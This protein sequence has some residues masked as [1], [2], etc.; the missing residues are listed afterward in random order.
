M[1]NHLYEHIGPILGTAAAVMAWRDGQKL[2]L[3]FLILSANCVAFSILERLR[4]PNDAR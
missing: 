4:K 1:K 3:V 2:W